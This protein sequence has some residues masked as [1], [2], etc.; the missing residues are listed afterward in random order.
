MRRLVLALVLSLLS[1]TREG[2]GPGGGGD[3]MQELGNEGAFFVSL[4]AIDWSKLDRLPAEIAAVIPDVEAGRLARELA[5]AREEVKSSWGA[6]RG[7]AVRFG[8]GEL[9]DPLPGLDPARP[10]LVAAGAP[11]ETPEAQMAALAAS[12]ADRGARRASGLRHRIVLP[13]LDAR[14][15]AEAL[16]PATQPSDEHLVRVTPRAR[17]VVV[18][19]VIGRGLTLLDAAGRDR[20]LGPVDRPAA[21]PHALFSSGPDALARVHLRLDRLADVGA[22]AGLTMIASVLDE[23]DIGIGR[24]EVMMGISEVLAALVYIDPA[25]AL[26]T[27]AVLDLPAADPGTASIYLVATAAGRTALAADARLARGEA[28]PPAQLDLA[29]IVAASP[30]LAR[31]GSFSS[32]GA[33]AEPVMECGFACSF[34]FGLGNGLVF[35]RAAEAI[36]PG[37]LREITTGLAHAVTGGRVTLAGTTLVV[38]PLRPV[39]GAADRA[40]G[41]TARIIDG[42]GEARACYLDALAALRRTLKVTADPGADANALLD[43][44]TTDEA[45]HLACASKDPPVA[46]RV[47]QLRAAI[48]SLRAVRD[49]KGP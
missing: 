6:V 46:D 13:A 26:F 47:A 34:Y 15:M 28:V 35:L 49:S 9:P 31:A 17:H 32:A 5:A 40:R 18:D 37:S 2:G 8:F 44:F 41:V 36:Q 11:I 21:T 38:E 19:L 30:T 1:C 39:A 20:A 29:A 42:G 48:A 7:I 16:A 25:S 4:G 33:L 23:P 43:R 45:A 10:I 14:A 27:D 24:T 22:S 3:A 12:V